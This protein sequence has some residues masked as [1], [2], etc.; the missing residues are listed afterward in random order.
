MKYFLTSQIYELK[1]HKKPRYTRMQRG[2][3][4]KGNP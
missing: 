1:F 2:F 4:E 3:Q